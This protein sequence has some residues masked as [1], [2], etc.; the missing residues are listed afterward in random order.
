MFIHLNQWAQVAPLF[1]LAIALIAVWV[2]WRQL[3]LNRVGQRENTAKATF[4]E[5]LKLAVEYPSFAEGQ[6]PS[7][8]AEQ[9]RYKW[10]VGYF[11]WAAEE[12]LAYAPEDNTWNRNLQM[13][14][15]QHGGYFRSPDFTEEEYGTYSSSTQALIDRAKR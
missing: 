10:F 6:Y 11:L 2:A 8:P 15:N 5:Y 9:E 4:R 12:L 1:T 3:N 14:A 7:D 13:I